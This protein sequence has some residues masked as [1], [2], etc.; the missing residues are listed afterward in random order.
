MQSVNSS[1]SDQTPTTMGP[2]LSDQGDQTATT[3][4]PP[5]SDQ[6]D[7][8]ATTMGPPPEK[9]RKKE[10]G[11][12]KRRPR[13]A[14]V[15]HSDQLCPSLFQG[16]KSTSSSCLFGD[17]C[18]YSH[19]CAKFLADKPPDIGDTCFL[20]TTLGRCPY[21]LAC[22]YGNSHVTADQQNVIN[23]DVYDP[24]RVETTLNIISRTLQEKLRKRKVELPK[25]D[26]FL[27]KLGAKDKGRRNVESESTETVTGEK[28]SGA[29]ERGREAGERGREGE[30]VGTEGVEAEDADVEERVKRGEGERGREEMEGEGERVRA[31]MKVEGERVRVEMNKEER[32]LSDQEHVGNEK[33][34]GAL[35]DEDMIAVRQA[36]KKQVCC[37][38][39][40]IRTP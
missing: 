30:G 12:N 37:G 29:G 9:R 23:E 5:L 7:Q 18:R 32:G 17:K 31:E 16:S 13:A 19:D 21:G 22:R 24:N 2:P 39:L 26:C 3:M 36:E 1:L 25:S 8:T 34:V 27:R 11:Q 4:G 20:F 33:T 35:T 28:N 38:T 10:R 6:G 40:L 14:R 15:N